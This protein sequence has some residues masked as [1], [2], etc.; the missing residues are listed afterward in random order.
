MLAEM[1]ARLGCQPQLR[2]TKRWERRRIK[3][4]F[5]RQDMRLFAKHKM[6]P[7]RRGWM[8]KRRRS[9]HLE[10]NSFLFPGPSG[11]A[12]L[13]GDNGSHSRANL[14]HTTNTAMSTPV[15][16]GS[17]RQSK[18]QQLSAKEK[19]WKEKHGTCRRRCNVRP[20]VGDTKPASRFAPRATSV[21]RSWCWGHLSVC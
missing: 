15:Q 19:I 3:T 17:R 21:T 7:R 16:S 20:V 11:F 13:P 5:S 1:T 12:A 14:A 2:D 8:A 6:I 4:A 9:T 10:Y 18:H